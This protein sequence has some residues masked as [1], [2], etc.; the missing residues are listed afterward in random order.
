M[1]PLYFYV[2]LECFKSLGNAKYKQE[3]DKKGPRPNGRD[4]SSEE[5]EK[6]SALIFR[7]E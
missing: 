6:I 2:G 5:I 7:Q 3:R 1:S 4:L